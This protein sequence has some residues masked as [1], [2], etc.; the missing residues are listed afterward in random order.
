MIPNCQQSFL[1]RL[2]I[3]LMS[4]WF[5]TWQK[6][7]G[8]WFR[9]KC[10][11][12]GSKNVNK[13]WTAKPW[14]GQ[15]GVQTLSRL[16]LCLLSLLLSVHWLYFLLLKH[17]FLLPHTRNIVTQF[18]LPAHPLW[19]GTA[20]CFLYPLFKNLR[21]RLWSSLGQVPS[22]YQCVVNVECYGSV[23]LIYWDHT[24]WLGEAPVS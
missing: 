8:K 19:K 2:T 14:E 21:E 7:K 16:L 15:R 24:I 1:K 10:R 6:P 23:W 20:I 3:L 13:C 11:W 12:I 17:Q 22:L 18:V 5:C 9:L 4:V